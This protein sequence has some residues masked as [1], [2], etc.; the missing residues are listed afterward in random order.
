M[1]STDS[2]PD[3]YF[4]DIKLDCTMSSPEYAIERAQM[5]SFASQWNP[6]PAHIDE[7]S[8]L[9][10]G[11]SGVTACGAHLLAIKDFLLSGLGFKHTVFA[12]FGFDE[13]RF[14]RPAFS[15]DKVWLELTWVTKR[16]SRSRPEYGIAR[17]S[18]RLV[19]SDGTCLVSLFDTVLIRCRGR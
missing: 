12:S 14:H 9:K 1:T 8:A 19:K 2:T 18:C 10:Q 7:E 11:F 15:G 4:D 17:N 6:L 16:L 3:L 5:V 13:V